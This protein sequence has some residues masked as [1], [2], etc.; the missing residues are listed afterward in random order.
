MRDRCTFTKRG[1]HCLGAYSLLAHQSQ[2]LRRAVVT[3]ELNVSYVQNTLVDRSVH[4]ARCITALELVQLLT[5]NR[6]IFRNR[7]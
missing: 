4:D 3:C 6:P 2:Q 1:S 5:A 7:K